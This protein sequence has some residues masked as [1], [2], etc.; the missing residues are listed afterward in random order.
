MA[1]HLAHSEALQG[2]FVRYLEHRLPDNQIDSVLFGHVCL[3]LFKKRLVDTC[4][5]LFVVFQ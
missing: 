4:Q 3:T 2:F 5:I 1:Y